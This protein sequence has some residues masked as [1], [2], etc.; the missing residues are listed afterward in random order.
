[1]IQTQTA[2]NMNATTFK[3]IDEMTTVARDLKA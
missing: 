3:T 2:Y 1:M